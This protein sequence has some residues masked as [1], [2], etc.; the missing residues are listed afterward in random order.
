[1]SFSLGLLIFQREMR[2]DLAVVRSELVIRGLWVAAVGQM[3]VQHIENNPFHRS[4]LRSRA[5][6]AAT[7]KFDRLIQIPP[8]KAEV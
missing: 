2:H 4:G 1:M 5:K 8:P 3:V 7:S 6:S